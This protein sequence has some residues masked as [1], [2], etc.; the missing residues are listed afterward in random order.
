MHVDVQFTD[1]C[2]SFSKLG[3]TLD[4]GRRTANICEGVAA[5]VIATKGKVNPAQ[6]CQGLI[7]DDNFLMM[8][9]KEDIRLNVVRMTKYL[10]TK[11]KVSDDWAN[12]QESYIW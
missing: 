12:L 7:N 6:E 10:E 1:H 8:S 3:D 11:K 4:I 9:P 5:V 2:H